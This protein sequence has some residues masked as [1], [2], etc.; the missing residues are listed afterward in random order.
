MPMTLY[1][2]KT[3]AKD[4]FVS[5]LPH[6]VKMYSC[7]PTVYHYLHI[8]NM[9]AYVF[10][11]ILRRTLEYFDYDVFHVIN[12]TDVGHLTSDSDTGEDKLEKGARREGKTAWDVAKF[13]TEAF[14]QDFK[15][16]N[17]LQPHIWARA[18][19]H[20]NEQIELVQ[21]L[22][23]KG[24]TYTIPQDG[25]YFDTSKF[26][27]YTAFA[28]INAE[29]LEAGKR[30]EMVEGK[31]NVTDFALWKFSPSDKKRDMEWE[32][33][34]GVGFPGWHIEC[35]AMSMKY[36]GDNFDIHT[37]GIDLI[38][39]HHTNEIAQNNCATGH[40]VVERWMHNEFLV[41]EAGDKMAKSAE[42]FLTVSSLEEKGFSPIAYRFFLLG[43]HYRKALRFS[44]DALSGA[45]EG[46]ARLQN[47]ARTISERVSQS[48]E[49]HEISSQIIAAKKI[50][51]EALSDDLNTPQALASIFDM[52]KSVNKAMDGG[53]AVPYAQIAEML[54]NFDQVL[55]LHLFESKDVAVPDEVTSLVAQRDSARANKDWKLSD[56][57]RSQI[58][59]LGYLVEDTPQG[60]RVVKK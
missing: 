49:N 18:T 16:M 32:S 34:W 10:N 29:E 22:E 51:D 44:L 9:R 58:E 42:N 21:S 43:A 17:V 19:D 38:P 2:T 47:F 31:K 20:I 25:I 37:G 41:T 39:I 6:K 59:T 24:F 14:M 53:V 45:S 50:F 3:R 56:E 55:G 48:G 4:D 35:S 26:P 15:A 8:G 40:D 57:L 13:Y 46:L 27:D 5:L 36:L 60:T 11:D 12:I 33:P 52:I 1:N 23:A 7:G 28:H 54:E 30:V